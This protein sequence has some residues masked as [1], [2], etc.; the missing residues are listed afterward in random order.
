MKNRSPSVSVAYLAV[1]I[2]LIVRYAPGKSY[3]SENWSSP[4]DD[5]H[6]AIDDGS[7]S[8]TFQFH[9]GWD[10]TTKLVGKYYLPTQHP[11]SDEGSLPPAIIMAHGLGL[12]QDCSLDKFIDTFRSEGIAV[13]TFDYATF[14]HSDGLP[15]HEV[16][17]KTHISDV[18]A[19]LEAVRI[20]FTDMVDTQ[21]LALWGTSLAGG[22]VL[23]SALS[24]GIT[25][26]EVRAVVVQVPH[27]ASG[28]EGILGTVISDPITYLPALGMILAGYIKSI[29]LKVAY[30]QNW[31]FPLHGKPGSTAAMQNPG[32]D[33]GYGDLCASSIAEETGMWRN[34]YTIMSVPHILLYRPMSLISQRKNIENQPSVLL[35][36]A[37]LDTLCPARYVTEA[38]KRIHGS[39]LFL[40]EG[41]GHFDVYKGEHL[42]KALD[43]EV[44]FLKK[45]LFAD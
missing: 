2:G 13:F 14:G 43:K 29:L 30:N 45:H 40:L 36:A 25:K 20:Q 5:V 8:G 19:A 17:P 34:A 22:H 1:V 6:H 44:P 27:I 26:K 9:G 4:N 3:S 23:S 16:H 38:S 10:G 39:E 33:E 32:D 35:V 31:Y 11:H 37:E 28:I 7:A 15:R 21:R 24:P 41:A 18:N 12:M 42:Q